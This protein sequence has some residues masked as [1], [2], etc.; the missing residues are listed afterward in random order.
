M[1]R[2]EIPREVIEPALRERSATNLTDQFLANQFREQVV[3][4]RAEQE[5]QCAQWAAD[6]QRKKA[7]A[8]VTEGHEDRLGV[9]KAQT[10]VEQ[11]RA[12]RAEGQVKSLEAQVRGLFK[13]QRT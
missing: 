1:I 6:E 9:A 13:G 2:P 11:E 4:K 8:A 3:Q 5:R 12:E 7:A 10:A